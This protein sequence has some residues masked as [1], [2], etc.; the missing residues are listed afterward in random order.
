[1][2][3]I[4][5][6]G[7][8]SILC[9]LI[10][11]MSLA[12]TSPAPLDPTATVT[13]PA[14]VPT[15]TPAAAQPVIP[16]V[17]EITQSATTTTSACSAKATS[18]GCINGAVETL[19]T[20]GVKLT[21][22]VT[23]AIGKATTLAN[24]NPSAQIQQLNSSC[25]N[26]SNPTACAS[27]AQSILSTVSGLGIPG[28]SAMA[29]NLNASIS[30]TIASISKT[31]AG[32][33]GQSGGTTT[34]TTKQ[35]EATNTNNLQTV[36]TQSLSAESAAKIAAATLINSG[37]YTPG[38][39]SQITSSQSQA[40]ATAT[41]STANLQA[42]KSNT[43]LAAQATTD[44]NTVAGTTYDNSLDAINATNQSLAGVVAGQ[45]RIYAATTNN[46]LLQ[47]QN[48]KQLAANYQATDA[49][50]RQKNTELSSVVSRNGNAACYIASITNAA[51][52][53][54]K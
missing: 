47:A 35:V 14:T 36:A 34:P 37:T 22:G 11:T 27:S 43:D 15:T 31:L 39:Q 1:L 28:L 12:A 9:A 24:F 54:S 2:N 26:I 10:P 7:L 49:A 21:P 48:L 51:A 30:K 41:L 23:E 38:V 16:N 20:A 32:V 53:C 19:S 18:A 42:M 25:S 8:S 46:T 33:I 45:E 44:A 50:D 29:T 17:G 6:W 13:T 3:K 52:V 5:I 4:T 40:L